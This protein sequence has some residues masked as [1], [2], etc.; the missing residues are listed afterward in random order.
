MQQYKLEMI[1]GM[2]TLGGHQKGEQEMNH[3]LLSRE[4]DEAHDCVVFRAVSSGIN[5]FL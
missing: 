3:C 2:P 5:N 4:R 1:G